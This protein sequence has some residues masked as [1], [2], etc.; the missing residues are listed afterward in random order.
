MIRFPHGYQPGIPTL[1]LAQTANW[2]A[3]ARG[4]WLMAYLE[5]RGDIEVDPVTLVA[6][7]HEIGM[8][9]DEIRFHGDGYIR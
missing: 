8:L 4:G 9:D 3:A 2:I 5:R 1:S 7:G 6:N